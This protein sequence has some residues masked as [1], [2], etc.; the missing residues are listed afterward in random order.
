M[1]Q[2]AGDEEVGDCLACARP[3]AWDGGHHKKLRWGS[4]L[5]DKGYLKGLLVRFILIRSGH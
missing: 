5:T 2:I 1:Q 3:K 4:Q